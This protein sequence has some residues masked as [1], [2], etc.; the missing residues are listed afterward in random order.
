MGVLGLGYVGIEAQDAAAWAP[1]ATGFAGMQRLEAGGGAAAY[2]VDDAGRRLVVMPAGRDGGA[3]YG[4]EV[5][6]AD[7]LDAMAARIEDR[8]VAVAQST[9]AERALRGVDG[10]VHCADPA[11]HRVELFH[12][13]EPAGGGFA[14]GRE[15][16]GFRTGGL[17]LG[18]VL[19]HAPDADGCAAFYRETLGFRLSDW[20]KTAFQASFLHCNPRHH[21]IAVVGARE[22]RLH[23]V[24]VELND[25][26][27]VGTAYDAALAENARV[28]ITLGRHDNDRMVSFYVRTPSG[29]LLEYGWGGRLI[30][31]ATWQ[32]EEVTRRSIWGHARVGPQPGASPIGMPAGGG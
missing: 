7:A 23:H 19:V 17:G 8:G 6:D 12:G 32:V 24:M 10:M 3:F 26:N 27:D 20:A 2:G 13:L 31:D 21:S 29:F 18:H 5:A 9:A 11:G 28:A 30:D 16:A 25:L 14:P 1:F 15:M 22:A 4:W